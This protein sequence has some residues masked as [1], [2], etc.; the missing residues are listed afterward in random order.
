V[1]IS[2]HLVARLLRLPIL[3]I[4]G[5]IRIRDDDWSWIPSGS[6][7]RRR[8]AA[9]LPALSAP[10]D[11]GRLLALAEADLE[12]VARVRSNGAGSNRREI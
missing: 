5:D 10:N 6:A 7:V 3:R 12:Q 8:P 1:R 4:E 11:V 2:I 9:G